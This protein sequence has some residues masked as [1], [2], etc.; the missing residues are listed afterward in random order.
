[1]PREIDAFDAVVPTLLFV[2]LASLLVQWGV[3]WLF[4]RFGL[5]R[6]VWH[7]PLFR[8]AV[9]ACVFAGLGLISLH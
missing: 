7:P 4:G 5:Y 2:F 1:M 9:F 6:H 3:D 8:L